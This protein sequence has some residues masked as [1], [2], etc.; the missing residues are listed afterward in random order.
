LRLPSR[1]RNRR[2]SAGLR[3]WLDQLSGTTK[4]ASIDYQPPAGFSDTLWFGYEIR[5]HDELLPA[6]TELLRKFSDFCR[7]TQLQSQYLRW[8]LL[9]MQGPAEHFEVR[10]SDT[11]LGWQRWLEL[12][13]LRL[14][15]LQ[16]GRDIE[17]ITL[18]VENLLPAATDSGDL[19]ADRR[20]R[21]SRQAL[22]DRLRSRLGLNAIQ[23][24][25]SRP[26]H[27]PEHCLQTAS[28]TPP[29]VT[30][31]AAAQ[32]PFW[33]L[34][35]PQPISER[36][37]TLFCNGT[38]QLLYGPE[39]IEDAWWH[40]PVSRDYYIAQREDN[41]PVWIFQ[42]RHSKRWYLHGLFD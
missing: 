41:E 10:S 4:E 9:K 16:I 25:G 29:R 5:Q 21:E 20:H 28:E 30:T 2:C 39:R 33:L 26:E 37:G 40:S 8:Q 19:F 27:L 34:P 17:G 24:I 13:S 36:R 6:M 32:R 23:H 22:V 15:T 7:Q 11:G 35:H 12:S 1:S 38:L 31:A 14:G 18:H 3:N 42:D